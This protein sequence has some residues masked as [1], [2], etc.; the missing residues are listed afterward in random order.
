MIQIT[1]IVSS[2]ALLASVF[3]LLI[4]LRKKRQS[5]SPLFNIPEPV[6]KQEVR[7]PMLTH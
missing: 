2:V 4:A 3:C 1:I 6:K 5:E 7:E